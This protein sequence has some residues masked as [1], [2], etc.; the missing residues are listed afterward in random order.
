MDFS[1]LEL[2]P[3]YVEEVRCHTCEIREKVASPFIIFFILF[4]LIL[5][6]A[7]RASAENKRPARYEVSKIPGAVGS[8]PGVI[9]WS[10]DGERLAFISSGALHV[11]EVANGKEKTVK[12]SRP[13]YVCWS[14][15]SEIFVIS[16]DG[17]KHLGIVDASTLKMREVKLDIE[18]DAVFPLGDSGKALI[19]VSDIRA[20]T[21]GTLVN[22]NFFLCDLKEEAARKIFTTGDVFP[23]RR[24]DINY[25]K[26]WLHAGINRLDGS[27]LVM[28]H[29]K[30]PA[31][32]TYYSKVIAVDP[33]SGTAETITGDS[34]GPKSAYISAGWSADGKR[35]AL[36]GIDGDLEI[37]NVR[38]ASSPVILHLRGF[39]PSWNPA[40]SQIFSGGSIADSD[41][42]GVKELIA[43][44][45]ESLG[46]WSPD[47]RKL[48]VASSGSLYLY[49][50]FAPHFTGGDSAFDEKLS[51]DIYLLKGL[52]RDRLIKEDEYAARCERLMKEKTGH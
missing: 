4:F 43:G 10:P 20:M 16:E 30:P 28:E 25:L 32:R 34:E 39:Y 40:G 31:W 44:A 49:G 50:G 45:D 27:F 18:P 22:F 17:K 41:G 12:I 42:K 29:I 5:F 46:E 11:Y 35:V 3:F 6:P 8:G 1:A 26:A 36:S 9:S 47:G 15:G 13:F 7:G 51:K 52:L 2:L 23:S 38:S 37:V 24:P 21:F 14:T 33:F 48:A 19:V